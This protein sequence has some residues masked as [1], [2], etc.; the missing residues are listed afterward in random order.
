M[1]LRMRCAWRSSIAPR[2]S[3]LRAAGGTHHADVGLGDGRVADDVAQIRRDRRRH[4]APD[5]AHAAGLDRG[6]TI[7][8]ARSEA[9]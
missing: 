5:H 3:T 4:A 2:S 6:S 1:T 8:V 7:V 9:R